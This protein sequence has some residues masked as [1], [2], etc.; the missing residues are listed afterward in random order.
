[1]PLKSPRSAYETTITTKGLF[2]QLGL[3]NLFSMTQAQKQ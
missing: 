1:M 3:K 2:S